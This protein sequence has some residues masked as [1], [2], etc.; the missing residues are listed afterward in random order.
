[1]GSRTLSWLSKYSEALG[2]TQSQNGKTNTT[3]R[4]IALMQLT[5]G[6]DFDT[7][8][9]GMQV[10]QDLRKY[11]YRCVS[12]ITSSSCTKKCLFPYWDRLYEIRK[13]GITTFL[14]GKLFHKL[15]AQR[16]SK[17]RDKRAEQFN[18]QWEWK[19]LM[20]TSLP[21]TVPNN[22]L[23]NLMTFNAG[24]KRKSTPLDILGKTILVT[25]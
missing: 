19:Q 1:M 12:N 2:C 18:S 4:F 24:V 11:L 3:G 20:P 23:S 22:P 17:V 8:V 25:V 10:T 9:E 14:G 6:I 16:T 5:T 13:N 21:P 15:Q 7:I